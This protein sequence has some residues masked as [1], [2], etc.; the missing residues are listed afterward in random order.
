MRGG[1][2]SP[3]GPSYP[4]LYSS[5]DED[6]ERSNFKSD[7]ST[8]MEMKELRNLQMQIEQRK[9]QLKSQ[10]KKRAQKRPTVVEV[11]SMFGS[12]WGRKINRFVID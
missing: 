6:Y 12:R 9:A 8:T 10:K 7:D 5:D 4:V 11:P 2:K 3:T 1:S